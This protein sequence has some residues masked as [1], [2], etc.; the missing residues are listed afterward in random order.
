MKAFLRS[1]LG[2]LKG[3]RAAETHLISLRSIY[4]QPRLTNTGTTRKNGLA[5]LTSG[6]AAMPW[7]GK[8]SGA[9]EFSA[10]H[11]YQQKRPDAPH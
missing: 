8:L 6:C 7:S 3:N 4:R 1:G 10:T 2:P 5:E 11:L 9:F